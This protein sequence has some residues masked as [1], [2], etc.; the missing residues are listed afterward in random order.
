[1][2]V[3]TLAAAEGNRDDL[4]SFRVIAEA[5]RIRHADELVRRALV[6]LQRLRY[7]SPQF[8]WVRPIGDG[9]VFAIDEPVRT[10]RI[11][12]VGQRH[13]KRPLA[14]FRLSHSTRSFPMHRCG[15][16]RPSLWKS[17]MKIPSRLLGRSSTS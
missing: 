5:S 17:K 9:Q 6:E 11:G 14:H 7:D 3:A 16:S 13:C 12:W 15:Y 4:T 2:G 8:G 10:R 1:M